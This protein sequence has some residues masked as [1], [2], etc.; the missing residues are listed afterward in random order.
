MV[1]EDE[2]V[3]FDVSYELVKNAP[4]HQGGH[5]KAVLPLELAEKVRRHLRARLSLEPLTRLKGQDVQAP[6]LLCMP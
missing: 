6:I 1:L 4:F 5:L 3:Q 2:R